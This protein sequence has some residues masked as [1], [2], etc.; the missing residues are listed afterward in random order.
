MHKLA[1]LALVLTLSSVTTPALSQKIPTTDLSGS[2]KLHDCFR[3]HGTN[4]VSSQSGFPT[5]AGQKAEYLRRQLRNFKHTLLGSTSHLNSFQFA[6][7]REEFPTRRDPKMS[8]VAVALGDDEIGMLATKLSRMSCDPS[9]KTKRKSDA[10]APQVPKVASRCFQCHESNGISASPF[11]PNLA[12]QDKQYLIT[13]IKLFR[14][15][16]MGYQVHATE[17]K[18]SHPIMQ[19]QTFQLSEQDIEDVTNYFSALSCSGD[20]AKAQNTN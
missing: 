12:G 13:Q 18:R 20:H 6:A 7:L 8:L 19:H 5:L 4:G 15:S 14:T 11:I 16:A 17:A 3:C 2:N 10:R 1:F 9:G